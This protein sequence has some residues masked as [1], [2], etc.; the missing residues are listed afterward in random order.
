MGLRGRQA[1]V[2]LCCLSAAISLLLPPPLGRATPVR[3]QKGTFQAAEATWLLRRDG[4]TYI[5][6]V[7]AYRLS[8]PLGAEKTRLF[9]DRSKCRMH[10]PKGRRLASCSLEGRVQKLEPRDLRFGPLLANARLHFGG[11]RIHWEGAEMREPE[12]D[13]FVDQRAA[14]ADAYLERTAGVAGRLFGRKM[15]PRG[16]DHATLSYGAYASVITS[17]PKA[18]SRVRFEL[19]ANVRE[20]A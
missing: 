18:G 10:G 2:R 5:Y 3:V 13:P 9:V 16:L 6:F 8:K 15:P 14:F 4:D 17:L 1:A 20:G 19:T 11:H 7:L 12:V